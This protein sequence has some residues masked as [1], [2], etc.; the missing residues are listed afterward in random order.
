MRNQCLKAKVSEGLSKKQD[1]AMV[2]GSSLYSLIT[3]SLQ[4][5]AGRTLT[6]L[7][8]ILNVNKFSFIPISGISFIRRSLDCRPG[9]STISWDLSAFIFLIFVRLIW[10]F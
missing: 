3:T 10:T 7:S 4:A 8:D 5:E 6:E 2:S 1:S 9:R